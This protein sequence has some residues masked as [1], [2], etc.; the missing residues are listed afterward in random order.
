[1]LT[2]AQGIEFDPVPE[3]PP[4]NWYTDPTD[5]SQYRYW[6]G[7]V[8]TDHYAPRYAQEPKSRLRSVG[9]LLRDSFSSMRRHWRGC[10]VASL[11]YIVGQVL[12][13]LLVVL[14]ADWILTGELGEL[15]DRVNEPGFDPTTR[16][17][18]AY[19]ESLEFDFSALN[20]VP[21]VLGMMILWVTG[22]FFTATAALLALGDFRGSAPSLPSTFLRALRR[23]P[24]IMGLQLLFALFVVAASGVVVLA[25]LVSPLLLILLIPALLAAVILSMPI[26]NLAY[27]VASAG[28]R[29]LPL[30]YAIRLVRRRFWGVFG[31]IAVV[32][33]I[34]LAFS[35]VIS[36][37]LDLAASSLGGTLVQAVNL[38]VSAVFALL[39]TVASAIIYHDLGGES[40]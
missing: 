26:F 6:D 13:L 12:A 32:V 25:A 14:S 2:N 23:V 18:E 28:L 22:S 8:W 39:V 30:P 24:R 33:L 7:S 37:V 10:S 38:G 1:M 31:R 17:N 29:E 15:W 3:L 5:E 4:P 16:E 27:I 9:A 35:F 11:V 19:F 21:A 40:E 34:A 36:A 20:F